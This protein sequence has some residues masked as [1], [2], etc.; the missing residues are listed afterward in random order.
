VGPLA[1]VL[2]RQQAHLLLPLADG[3]LHQQVQTLELLLVVFVGRGGGSVVRRLPLGV[4]PQLRGQQGGPVAALHL[5][6]DHVLFVLLAQ[7][8][9]AQVRVQL[10]AE[11]AARRR[12]RLVRAALRGAAPRR[13][14]AVRLLLRRWRRRRLTAYAALL[15][16]PPVDGEVLRVLALAPDHLWKH[17][18]PRVDEPVADLYKSIKLLVILFIQHLYIR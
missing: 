16:A 3:R 7:R 17:S 9:A 10:R 13:V 8:V 12:A 14:E 15:L 5:A 11:R 1:L 4:P 18:A 2:W 6:G